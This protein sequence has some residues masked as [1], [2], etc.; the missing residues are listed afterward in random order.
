MSDDK[1]DHPKPPQQNPSQCA[2][3]GISDG[4]PADNNNGHQNEQRKGSNE[5]AAEASRKRTVSSRKIEANQRN[6]WK[7]TGPTTPAG[8]KRISRNAVRHGFFSKFLLI[9]HRDGKES[10]SEFDDFYASVHKYYEP[11]GW[12]EELWVEK[13]AVWSWRLRRLIRC[14][15][16]QI[17]RALAGHSYKLQQ[18]KADNLAE[19]DSPPSSSLELD[20]STDYLFLPEKEEL[21]KLLRYEATINRQLNHAMGELERVQTRRNG[22]HT[23][24]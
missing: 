16:G 15:S 22:E 12:L 2:V 10:Q 3:P 7:S 20:T 1:Q 6:S 5:I 21:D 11:V 8:K 19:P 13:T 17:D 4:P 18:S 14:E 9:Q 23:K 24:A